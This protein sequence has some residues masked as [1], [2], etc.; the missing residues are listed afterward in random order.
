LIGIG[1]GAFLLHQYGHG[2]GL[3]ESL[4][5]E[6][7]AF[8][9]FLL[10]PIMFQAGFSMRAD[11]FFRNI[12]TINAYAIGA[13]I[14]ASFVFSFIFYYGMLG[15][16]YPFP[17]IDTL[18]FGCFISAID[19]VATISIFKSMHVNDKVYMIVFGESTLNDAVAIALSSSTESVREELGYGHDPDY[20]SI[21]FDSVVYFIVFFVGSILVGL[22]I[23]V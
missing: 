9:L 22:I 14:I 5:F 8:F 17:Y 6:P 2:K 3:A 19:P 13:T 7:H 18:N 12:L 10:P 1:L 20:A 21:I 11:T 23:S 4:E 16:D 15:S